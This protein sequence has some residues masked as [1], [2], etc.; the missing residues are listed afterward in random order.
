MVFSCFAVYIRFLLDFLSLL[1]T[2]FKASLFCESVI[3]VQDKI[4]YTRSVFIDSRI[5]DWPRL[6][7]AEVGIVEI[8]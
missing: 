1:C 2:N 5:P 8:L 7:R 3:V 6:R 4:F